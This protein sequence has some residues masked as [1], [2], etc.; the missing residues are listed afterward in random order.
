MKVHERAIAFIR[1][2]KTT[3]GDFQANNEKI[4]KELGESILVT[5]KGAVRLGTR[6]LVPI[7]TQS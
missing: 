6:P 7:A 3:Y 2:G 4:F 1:P 5:D